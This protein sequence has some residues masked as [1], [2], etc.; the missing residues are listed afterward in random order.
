V[1]AAGLLY[2]YLPGF[3]PSYPV[4]SQLADRVNLGGGGSVNLDP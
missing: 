3:L 1:F 4:D 2:I